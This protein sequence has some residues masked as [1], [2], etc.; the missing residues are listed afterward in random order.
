MSKKEVSRE[1]KQSLVLNYLVRLI[2]LSEEIGLLQNKIINQ[3]LCAPGKFRLEIESGLL[4]KILNPKTQEEKQLDK[5]NEERK[6]YINRI[7]KTLQS[8]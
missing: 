1:E 2:Q 5:T 3:K 6:Y 7:E 4:I 8:I